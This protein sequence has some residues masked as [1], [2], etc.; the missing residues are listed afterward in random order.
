MSDAS[1]P[2]GGRG[3]SSSNA[4]VGDRVGGEPNHAESDREAPVKG[5]TPEGESEH[6]DTRKAETIT[7]PEPAVS[8]GA[9]EATK[10]AVEEGTVPM[11]RIDDAV[12]VIESLL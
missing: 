10:A 5:A 7:P 1:A 4:P 11:S 2:N 3:P 6:V 9:S 12:T 8:T